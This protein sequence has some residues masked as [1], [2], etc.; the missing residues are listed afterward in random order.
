MSDTKSVCT[1]DGTKMKLIC[2]GQKYTHPSHITYSSGVWG[3]Y[4][5]DD[6]MKRIVVVDKSRETLTE[7][8]E[9]A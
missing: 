3:A 8:I 9:N 1:R 5:A 6:P 4:R 7:I 2:L